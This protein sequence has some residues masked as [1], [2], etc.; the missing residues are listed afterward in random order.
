MIELTDIKKMEETIRNRKW[1]EFEKGPRQRGAVTGAQ[2]GAA[3][4]MATSSRSASTAARQS[5]T[6]SPAG[7]LEL[8]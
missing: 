2:S 6:S 4:S 5:M 3:M 1:N 7:R 8:R